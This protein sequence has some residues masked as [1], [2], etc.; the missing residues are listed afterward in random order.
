MNHV[1]RS[2]KSVRLAIVLILLIL[3]T[4]LA[5]TFVPQGEDAAFYRSH[6]SPGAAGAITGT[7]FDHFFSS[8]PF[9][10]LVALFVLNLG[11]CTV[12]RLARRLRT[13][14]PLRL[15]PDLVHVAL[16]VLVVGAVVSGLGRHD[17]FVEMAAGQEAALTPHY[18]IRVVSLEHSTY[19]NGAPR[20]WVS[21]VDVLR[22]GAVERSAVPIRVNHPLRLTGV[23]VYQA[24]W[25]NESSFVFRDTGGQQVSVGV[26]QGFQDG[27][28][29]WLLADSTGDRGSSKALFR[30]YRGDRLVSTRTVG[31]EEA[32]GPYTLV[33]ISPKMVTGLREVTDAGYTTVV[34]AAVLLAG[35][36]ALTFAQR[37]ARESRQGA[38]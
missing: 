26:G 21:T 20:A 17:A 25:K 1:Y 29:Y 11:T 30:E 24:S 34:V 13:R 33:S 4:S 9:L 37:E 27:G 35:G 14:A 32:L 18:T 23:S 22:D 2:L 10:L 19:D 3:V 15:G 31:V 38:R 12:D 7:G 5:S 36:L 8:V 28:S 16:L 6:Y